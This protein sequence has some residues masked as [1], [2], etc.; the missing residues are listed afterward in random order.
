MK[1][2]LNEIRF[3]KSHE[4]NMKVLLLTNMIYGFVL[5]VVEIFAGAYVMRDTNDPAMVAYYQLAMYVGVVF[6]SMVNGFFLKFL[7]NGSLK[8]EITAK[9]LYAASQ[10][11]L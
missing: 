7:N 11:V 10:R 9:R 2:I 1:G 6:T 3:F 8:F 5:P 4:H